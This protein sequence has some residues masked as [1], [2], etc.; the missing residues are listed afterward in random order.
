MLVMKPPLSSPQHNQEHVLVASPRQGAMIHSSNMEKTKITK[1]AKKKTIQA[2]TSNVTRAL[3]SRVKLPKQSMVKFPKRTRENK[4]IQSKG[5]EK[6]EQ[7]ESSHEHE[8]G[9]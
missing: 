6:V 7:P 8:K 5:K 1:S 3:R 4:S 2:M 9:I